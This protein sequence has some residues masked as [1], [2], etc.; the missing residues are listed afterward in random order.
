MSGSLFTV[1]PTMPIAL[2]AVSGALMFVFAIYRMAAARGFRGRI[3][4]FLR[5]LMVLLAVIVVLRPIIPADNV[6]P[7]VSSDVE[8][9]FVV[10]TTTSMAAEDVGGEV[11][12]RPGTRLDGVKNDIEQLCA[13]LTGAQFSLTTFDSVASQRVPLTRDQSALVS[14]SRA[15]TPEISGYSRGSSIDEALPLMTEILRRAQSERPDSRRVLFYFGDGEQTRTSQEP[16]DFSVVAPLLDGGAAL[17][18]GTLSGGAMRIFDGFAD[19]DPSNDV[20]YLADPATGE[21]ALS[22]IDE[23]NLRTIASQLGVGYLYRAAGE[24]IAQA[25]AGIEVEAP[26]ATPGS[27]S[28]AGELY[29]VAAIGL[30][31]LLLGELVR[32]VL[33]IART[34]ARRPASESAVT[35]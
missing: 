21:Q 9:Y 30:A 7:V 19:D 25:V 23:T 1:D 24:P 4:G 14:A 8:V 27:P 16:A 34:V 13:A 15:I 26:T 3:S 22:T 31:L 33:A 35:G 20:A 28:I 10:D 11:D 29:W 5:V 17:G 2:I 12:G 32:I 6:S 18:Y